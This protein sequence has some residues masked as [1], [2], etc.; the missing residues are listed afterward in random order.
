MDCYTCG[1]FFVCWFL[2]F[3]C[4]YISTSPTHFDAVLLSFVVEGMCIHLFRSFPEE[5]ISMYLY[6]CVHGRR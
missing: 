2:Y 6:I 1:D 3:W 4:E 5:I